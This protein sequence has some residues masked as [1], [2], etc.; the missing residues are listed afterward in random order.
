M[1]Q[2]RCKPIVMSRILAHVRLDAVGERE[3]D[4]NGHMFGN[5][6]PLRRH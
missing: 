6:P 2:R 4:S 5:S 3:A 1:K